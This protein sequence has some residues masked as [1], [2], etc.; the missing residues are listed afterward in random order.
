[1]QHLYGEGPPSI[2]KH[3]ETQTNVFLCLPL[4]CNLELEVGTQ[5][6]RTEEEFMTEHKEKFC[7]YQKLQGE[8]S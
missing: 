7:T 6:C 8:F 3:K 4:K 5:Q 2:C 1:M